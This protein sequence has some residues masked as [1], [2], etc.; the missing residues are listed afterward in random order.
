MAHA[1]LSPSAAHRWLVCTPSVAFGD[2][3]PVPPSSEAAAEGTLAHAWAEHLLLTEIKNEEHA[4]PAEVCDPDM[5]EYAEGYLAYVQEQIGKHGW[6]NVETKVQLGDWAPESFG[7]V[8]ALVA[9]GNELHVIDL[10]YGRGVEVSAVGNPQLRLYAL[11][12][13]T[14]VQDVY[15]I[16]TVH[17]HIYQP[18]INNF[19]VDTLSREEL[20]AWGEEM[21]PKAAAAFNGE[22]EF[23]AG[24]H[25]LF[26]NGR[27][28]CKA[29]AEHN[30]EIAKEDNL[31]LNEMGDEEITQV[32]NRASAIKSWLNA[33]EEHALNEALGG[34]N[35]AGFKLVAGRSVRVYSDAD[36]VVEA[37]RAGGIEDA[38]I[39]ERKLVGISGME[40]A[41]GKK[42][43]AELTDGL[44]IK[45]QGKPTL[46]PESDKR[47]ELNSV[48]EDFDL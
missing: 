12:A 14:E 1:K 16:D 2:L 23:I 40:K 9:K 43:F 41:I 17:M 10:K 15:D 18:R 45:P 33:I 31:K 20:L 13:L 21:K 26:C 46:V 22:G 19:S 35:W 3:F 34:K 6:L 37:L 47:Q 5:Q 24:E 27:L 25:C 32:L 29:L 30:L 8:D 7:T 36:K 28:M 11:G 4:A 39:Y 44:I 42:R 48:E 38:L